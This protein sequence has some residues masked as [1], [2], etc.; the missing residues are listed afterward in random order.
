MLTG[1]KLEGEAPDGLLRD[2]I[3]V[4]VYL[5][6]LQIAFSEEYESILMPIHFLAA[7]IFLIITSSGRV[8]KVVLVVHTCEDIVMVSSSTFF[9]AFL[10]DFLVFRNLN[11]NLFQSTSTKKS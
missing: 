1:N 11:L 9:L 8:L 6:S 3:T 2:G 5:L 4:Y 7:E 10:T